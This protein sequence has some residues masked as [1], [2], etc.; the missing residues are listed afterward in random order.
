MDFY[1]I[2]TRCSRI[3]CHQDRCRYPNCM[4]DQ[5]CKR[6]QAEGKDFDVCEKCLKEIEATTKPRKV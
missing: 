6:L 4:I 2:C 1:T 5:S 3:I